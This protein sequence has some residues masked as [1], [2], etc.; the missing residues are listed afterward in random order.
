MAQRLAGRR[1]LV[2]GA[3]QQTYGMPDPPIGIGS[4]I[5]ELAS[6]EGAADV[7]GGLDAL[8][9]NTGIATGNRLADTTPED[10]DRTMAVNVR[11]H[12]LA[13]RA[14]LD[15]LMPGSAVTITSSTAASSASTD[16]AMF[17]STRSSYHHPPPPIRVPGAHPSARRP[18]EC[19]RAP[20]WAA[21]TRT[22]GSLR[23]IRASQLSGSPS[24]CGNPGG[25]GHH[26]GSSPT[27]DVPRVG[28]A[29]V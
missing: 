18:S 29:L 13:L 11:A 19:G 15:I 26:E 14:A 27:V 5:C 21:D 1:L 7:L 9:L 25:Q 17:R 4:A 2:V 8:A 20:R 28:S 22:P 23:D 3:G 24:P 6:L 10:W 16:T 12:F